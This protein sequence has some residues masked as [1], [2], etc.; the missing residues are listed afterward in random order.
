MTAAHCLVDAKFILVVMGAHNVTMDEPAQV[1]SL[2]T[3]YI[4]NE[5]YAENNPS[6]TIHDTA[7]I[8]L[9]VPVDFTSELQFKLVLSTTA[10]MTQQLFCSII[11]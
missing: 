10:D 5:E 9:D 2:A 4:V 7:L 1:A 3:N 11:S 6:W 8:K